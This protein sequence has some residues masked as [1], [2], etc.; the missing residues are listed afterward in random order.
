MSNH[1]DTFT[2]LLLDHMQCRTCYTLAVHMSTQRGRLDKHKPCK[3]SEWGVNRLWHAAQHTVADMA[4]AVSN[5]VKQRVHVQLAFPQIVSIIGLQAGLEIFTVRS[6]LVSICCQV[7][8]C[9][10]GPGLAIIQLL[11]TNHIC[12]PTLRLFDVNL[13]TVLLMLLRQWSAHNA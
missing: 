12:I 1:C 13:Q 5:A 9:R 6:R 11:P 3:K 7:L 10:C 4:S 8:V 2:S